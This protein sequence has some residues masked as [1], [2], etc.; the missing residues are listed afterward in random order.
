MTMPIVG[1]HND[2]AQKL[3]S[4]LPTRSSGVCGCGAV[5]DYGNVVVPPR[6]EGMCGRCAFEHG[7]RPGDTSRV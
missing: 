4:D 3:H 6:Y 1:A 5:Y 2:V 7:L